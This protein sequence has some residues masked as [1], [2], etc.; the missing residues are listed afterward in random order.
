M[1]KK[2][3]IFI[4]S[5]FQDL[6]EERKAI[7]EAVIEMGHLPI[8]MEFFPASNESSLE[9]IKKL[10]DDADYYALIFGARYGSVD[11][12]LDKS[13]TQLEYE[14]AVSKNIPILI[15]YPKDLNSVII[16]KTD[17]N[18]EKLKKLETFLEDAKSNR[19]GKE[20]D[21]PDTLKSKFI[22]SMMALTKQSP[23]IGWI[24]GNQDND[25]MLLRQL[26]EIR[27]ENEELRK[28][29]SEKETTFNITSLQLSEFVAGFNS[30]IDFCY[31]V[32]YDTYGYSNAISSVKSCTFKAM[33]ADMGYRFLDGFFES[34]FIDV[35]RE[36]VY[37]D[38]YE[39]V[40]NSGDAVQNSEYQYSFKVELEDKLIKQLLIHLEVLK[41]IV[42]DGDIYYLTNEGKKIVVEEMLL[43][44]IPF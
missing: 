8:G 21:N 34:D 24:K 23:R 9:Y 16:G 37:E 12:Q 25:T 27:K 11:P 41:I 26:N 2:Y 17:Q 5:T 22:V 42:K 10:I 18:P 29:L 40:K 33:L 7:T 4:S 28:K 14:Y 38:A 43:I 35:I 19:L 31:K 1:E 44:S 30:K 32:I 6:V 36:Y 20:Y 15:F 3:Q 13:Y 39:S